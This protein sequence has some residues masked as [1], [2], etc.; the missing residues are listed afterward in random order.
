M[1]FQLFRD[2]TRF[3][4]VKN[5]IDYFNVHTL[6]FDYLIFINVQQIKL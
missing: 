1:K 2:V 6:H 4:D 3:R 5:V